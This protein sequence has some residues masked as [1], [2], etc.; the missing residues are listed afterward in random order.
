MRYAVD[1]KLQSMGSWLVETSM[2]LRS[3]TEWAYID[4]EEARLGHAS[5]R[6]VLSTLLQCCPFEP[7][8]NSIF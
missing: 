3:G 2:G 7:C 6:V 4:D 5:A 8:L 1:R